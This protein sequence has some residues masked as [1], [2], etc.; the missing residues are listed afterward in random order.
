[1]CDREDNRDPIGVWQGLYDGTSD[2]RRIQLID[3]LHLPRMHSLRY[4]SIA[5]VSY[6][7]GSDILV[8]CCGAVVL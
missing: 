6:A 8:F 3:T 5:T 2:Q 1:M 4:F 7:V